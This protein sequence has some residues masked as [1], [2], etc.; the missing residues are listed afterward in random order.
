MIPKI[1]TLIRHLTGIQSVLQSGVLLALRTLIGWQF[2]LTGKGKLANLERTAGF[3]E[4][5]H[6]PAPGFHAG[7]VGSIEMIGGL[8][9]LAGL[10]TRFAAL[11]LF[12]AM[13]VAYLTAHREDG[14][15]SIGDFIEQAPFPFLAVCLVLLAFGPGR[16]S[17]DHVTK[18]WLAKCGCNTP[19]C[20]E[21]HRANT[22]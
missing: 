4:S 16:F 15:N 10:A 2:F 13:V 7:M 9:L 12:G 19:L 14:F 5:L 21:N 18:F 11:P 8:M 3:F 22:L 1:N 17:I 6:I 20:G